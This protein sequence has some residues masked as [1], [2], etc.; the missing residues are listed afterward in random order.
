MGLW[1][2]HLHNHVYRFA[3][4]YHIHNMKNSNREERQK[5]YRLPQWRK[6]SKWYLQ[7]HPLCEECLKRNVITLIIWL[8][9]IGDAL[10]KF[11]Q[12]LIYVIFSL[13]HNSNV[14]RYV[15]HLSTLSLMSFQ[16]IS[17]G[18]HQL[19]Y[20]RFLAYLFRPSIGKHSILI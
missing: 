5:I 17:K 13:S 3:V 8:V 18:C 1:L 10:Y 9:F 7:S 19:K 12:Y 4:L 2:I 16:A 11:R 6:L 20:V 15:T 14:F